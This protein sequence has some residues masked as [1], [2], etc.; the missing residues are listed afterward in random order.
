MN[1]SDFTINF[2]TDADNHYLSNDRHLKYESVEQISLTDITLYHIQEITFEDKEP[3]KEALENVL[4]SLRIEGINFVYIILGD[5]KRVNFY[6]GVAKDK[7][8]EIELPITVYDIGK[9]VLLPSLKGNFRGSSIRLVSN[10]NN[11]KETILNKIAGMDHACYLEGVPG[12][13][14]DNENFQGVDRLVDVMLGDDF[15]VIVIAKPLMAQD[16]LLI[17]DNLNNAYSGIV[18]FVKQSVQDGNSKNWGITTSNTASTSDTSGENASSSI[19]TSESSNTGASDGITKTISQGTTE[20][21]SSTSSGG[22]GSNS[23]SN[24][25]A[26]EA[27]ATNKSWGSSK[28]RSDST[29]QGSSTT[30]GTSASVSEGTSEGSS[31]STSTTVEFIKKDVQ[32]W[33]KYIDE[34]IFARLD[35]GKGRG[36]FITTSLL[37]SN[38]VGSLIKL[39]NT[40]KSLY[41]GE[42]G[43]KVSLRQIGLS[44][45]DSRLKALKSFQIPMCKKSIKLSDNEIYARAALSQFAS[46]NAAFMGSWISTKEL[47]LIAGLPKKEIVGLGLREEVEFGLNFHKTTAGNKSIN[48]GNVVQSG[49]ELCNVPI[50][51]DLENLNKHTFVTGV[52]GSGKTTTCQKILIDSNLPFLVIEPAKTEYRI[53]TKIYEDLL[54]FTLGR[55][56]IAPFRLNPFE[57]FPHESITSRVDMIKASMEAAFD[58][59]AAIPQIIEAAIY[60]CYKD[61][62]WNISNNT[63]TIF[64]D[65]FADGV[66][67][68]PTLSDLLSKTEQVVEKQGFDERLKKDY[69]GSIKARLQ[70]LVIGS[71]GLMLDTKRSI[72]FRELLKRRVVLEIEE[73]RSSAEKSLIIG[74]VLTNLIE[75]VRAEFTVNK[76]FKHI[77]LIEEAHRLLSA[78]T[79]G[80]SLN[81]KQSVETFTDMLAEVRKYGECLIISDQIPSKLAKEVL[82]NTSTKIVHKIFA[83]D[84][85][86][87]IGNT[88][89]LTDEQKRFLSNLS[90]G[91]AIIFTQGYN[92]A[93]QVQIENITDTT[94][95]EEIDDGLIRDNT[96]AY[97][98]QTYKRGVFQGTENLK[99][100]P[101]YELMKT[102]IELNSD[103]DFYN[104]YELF[105]KKMIFTYQLSSRIKY[106]ICKFGTEPV[107]KY[108]ISIFYVNVSEDIQSKVSES[109][110]RFLM[111]NV[112]D[113]SEKSIKR[114]IDDLTIWRNER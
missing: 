19:Q 32:E 49:N 104:S 25:S 22:S 69:I 92:K 10:E 17:E 30:K 75:A 3:R 11:E 4:G 87:A 57:F 23:G 53:L 16:L 65:P 29:S 6:F 83:Q 110:E 26:S 72:D 33:I 58:M 21:K 100:A 114:Y 81:K 62:G 112:N 66:Y 43:N 28:S 67:A 98:C 38:Q 51:I 94:S 18:P 60:E 84:D 8:L 73:I 37:L 108:L 85:K 106:Y 42:K 27:T 68:F 76:E 50:T 86:D 35:Y 111:D 59:E 46:G 9:F 52:T 56:T 7:S 80:D 113:E 47:S 40:M 36:I 39:E 70:G 41:S 31:T 109:I 55:D 54:I 105:I 91:R 44:R 45:Q 103:K 48:L 2:L 82:K 14:E 24:H 5:A 20:G 12:V 95:K 64:V 71:K 89:A 63:N 78:Y 77:T 97:Y 101:T 102:Y 74:F 93:I 1:V 96:I 13:N 34:T 61:F 90:T 88:M 107:K 79:A 15:G 99:E